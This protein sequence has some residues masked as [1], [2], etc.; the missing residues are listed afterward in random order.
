MFL[1]I[2]EAVTEGIE[3]FGIALIS[4]QDEGFFLVSTDK[5]KAFDTEAESTS[6]N[7]WRKSSCN[8][9]IESQV[10][11]DYCSLFLISANLEVVCSNS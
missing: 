2:T 9:L 8:Q 4:V 6:A 5:A 3:M 10:W 7:S 1:V 11:P